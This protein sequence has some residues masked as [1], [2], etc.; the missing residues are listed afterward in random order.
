[1]Y[2]RKALADKSRSRAL[3]L[4]MRV[5]NVMSGRNLGTISDTEASEIFHD[6]VTKNED[7]ILHEHEDPETKE[8]IRK[9]RITLLPFSDKPFAFG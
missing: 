8:A 3:E 5:G 4:V 2:P 6:I 7:L 1:M 9:I